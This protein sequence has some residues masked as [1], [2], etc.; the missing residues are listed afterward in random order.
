MAGTVFLLVAGSLAN[1]YKKLRADLEEVQLSFR[2]FGAA[3]RAAPPE[4][5]EPE[6]EPS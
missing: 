2:A 1:R 4:E 3:A 5:G 6:G